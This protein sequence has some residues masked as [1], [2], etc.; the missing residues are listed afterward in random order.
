MRR[1][2]YFEPAGVRELRDVAV[3]IRVILTASSGGFVETHSGYGSKDAHL[4]GKYGTGRG[5]KIILKT[6]YGSISLR[7]TSSDIP[8][9]PKP[10]GEGASTAGD[11]EEN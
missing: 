10:T 2:D 11:S 6:S 4:E 8:A 7:R 3:A 5:P 9:P 1:R